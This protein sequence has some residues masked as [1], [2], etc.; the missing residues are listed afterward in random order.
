VKHLLG[1]VLAVAAIGTIGWHTPHVLKDYQKA[2]LTSFLNPQA[3]RSGAGYHVIQSRIAIG[4]GQTSGKGW[5]HGTQSQLDFIPENH[6]DFIFTVAAEEFGF[7]GV[8]ALLF[9]YFL[10]LW[11]GMVIMSETEDT[12]GR[13]A[14]SGVVCMLLFHV[15]VNIGMTL[16]IMPVTGVPLPFLSYGGSSL[17]ANMMATGLLVGI[18]MR[19]HKINF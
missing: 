10:L 1:F 16:G 17:L 14:A 15:V 18:G 8:C 5:L 19:R 11:K 2:R 3:D 4:S 13:L 12:L 6:T 9:L 7:V